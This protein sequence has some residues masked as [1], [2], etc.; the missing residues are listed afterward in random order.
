MLAHATR[1][2]AAVIVL[3]SAG[4]VLATP[5]GKEGN[6]KDTPA[7]ALR[8]ALDYGITL[9]LT[10]TPMADALKQLG[11]MAKVNIVWDKNVVLGNPDEMMVSLKA[12]ETKL[13]SVLLT[14]TGQHGLS[15]GIVGDHILVG[16]EEAVNYRQLRQRV[17]VQFDGEPLPKALKDLSQDTGANIVLDP[18]AQK[19]AEEHKVVLKLE[20]APLESA[21][22]L[23]AEVAG[24]K[25]VRLGNVLFV[26]TEERADKL[27][28]DADSTP[29]GPKDA[30][31]VA[32][33][34]VLPAGPAPAPPA[35]PP[36]GP[37]IRDTTY[38][39]PVQVMPM[40]P[41]QQQPYRFQPFRGVVRQRLQSLFDGAMSFTQVAYR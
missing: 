20:E 19:T 7:D 12:K 15:Y 9:E 11:E 24:L 10:D 4:V 6:R 34:M 28:A 35:V 1:F 23:M 17:K 40:V 29:Q 37:P 32:S 16:V 30:A 38:V 22:R 18:R 39:V 36:A 2:L 3:T 14:I 26:T 8:K 41:M 27:K 13:R 5:A 21:V 33:P 31:P 25:P